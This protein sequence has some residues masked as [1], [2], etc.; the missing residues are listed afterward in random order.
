VAHKEQRNG[1]RMLRSGGIVRLVATDSH[2]LLGDEKK[3]RALSSVLSQKLP[4]LHRSFVVA[5]ENAM[6]ESS[7]DHGGQRIRDHLDLSTLF[8]RRS[9]QHFIL[10]RSS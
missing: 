7:M 1:N 6:W 10:H 9:Y 5:S 4:A 8:F 3:A 2:S